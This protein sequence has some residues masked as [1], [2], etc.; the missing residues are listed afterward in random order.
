VAARILAGNEYALHLE[1]QIYKMS[2]Q[3]SM[4]IL[5]YAFWTR[6]YHWTKDWSYASLCLDVKI[7]KILNCLL[8]SPSS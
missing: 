8:G 3:R 7:M 4:Y 1:F 5:L 2:F 6:E